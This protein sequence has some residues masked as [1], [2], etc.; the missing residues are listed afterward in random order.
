MGRFNDE[1]YRAGYAF[2][3]QNTVGEMLE[4]AI[5]KVFTNVPEVEILL[6]VHDELV[7]QHL[8]KDRDL[9]M[10][11]VKE[12]MEMT[13]KIKDRSLKIPVELSYGPSWGEMEEYEL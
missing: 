2:S 8:P 1:L 13:I 11:K 3:P 12:N 4:V 10:K 9:V 7:W 5:Q 6:N